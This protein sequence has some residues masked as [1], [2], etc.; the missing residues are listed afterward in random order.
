MGNLLSMM[1]ILARSSNWTNVSQGSLS[2]SEMVL[3]YRSLW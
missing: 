1:A 3:S 2:Y